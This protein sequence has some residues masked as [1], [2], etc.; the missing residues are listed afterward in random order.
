MKVL[1]WIVKIV[2]GMVVLLLVLL[3][4]GFGLVNSSSFQN[5]ML[6]KATTMLA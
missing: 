6:Q 1:G 5:K 2:I 4:V 3:G